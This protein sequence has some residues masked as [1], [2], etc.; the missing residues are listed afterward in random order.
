MCISILS[1]FLVALVSFSTYVLVDST[2]K[3]TPGKAFVSLSLF[4]ILR[5]PVGNLPDVITAVVQV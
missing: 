2:H 1:P 5:Q 4:N 3:L